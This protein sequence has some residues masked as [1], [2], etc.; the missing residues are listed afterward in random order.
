ML[1]YLIVIFLLLPFLDLYL[2]IEL[3][4]YI[5]FP[6]T[7]GVIIVTGILGAFVVKREGRNVL[8]KLQKS[9]SAQEVS[10]NLLEGILLAFGGLMLLSPG[11]VTD[12]I[13]FMMVLRPTRE[14]IMLKIASK[15]KEKSN[16]QVKT[17]SF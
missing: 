17:Y 5:G 15:L 16:F 13:G 1:F 7:L 12:V 3:T 2:L 9:V 8:G 14:R 10:R 6:A 4:S 11:L